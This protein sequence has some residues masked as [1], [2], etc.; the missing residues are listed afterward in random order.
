MPTTIN[1]SSAI[2]LMAAL[3]SAQG[4]ETILLAGGD[5]GQ[6]A[7]YATQAPTF[8]FSSKVTIKSAVESDPATFSSVILQEVDVVS[9]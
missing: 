9:E 2:E 3:E 6:L 1:V 5:Y 7:L 4:G 8:K